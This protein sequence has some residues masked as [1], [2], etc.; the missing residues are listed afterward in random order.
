MT[1]FGNS[2]YT[3]HFLG[4]AHLPLSREYLSCAFTQKILKQ[5]KMFLSLGHRVYLYGARSTVPGYDRIEDYLDPKGIYN[6]LLTIV[7]THTVADIA[8]DYGDGD[9]KFEIG[10]DYTLG[11]YRHDFDA[12]TKPSTQKFYDTAI[13]HIKATAQPDHFLLLSMGAYHH[14][15]ADAVQLYLRCES[16][17]GYRGSHKNNWRCFESAGIQHFTYGAESNGACVNG[18]NYD[19]VIP[20]CFDPAEFT[21]SPIPPGQR[22][23]PDGEPYA[24][25]IGRM[26]SRKGILTAFAACE[27]LNLKLILVGQGGRVE[28]DTFVTDEFRTTPTCPWEYQGFADVA[29]RRNLFTNA[30]L[31]FVPTDYIEPFA[32]VHIESMISGTPV[33]T[34]DFGVFPTT[35]KNGINGYRCHSLDDFV[36]AARQCQQWKHAVPRAEGKRYLL[37]QVRWD[38]QQWFDDLY[39]V[40]LSTLYPDQQHGW[41]QD[42]PEG[43]PQVWR[44]HLAER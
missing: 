23:D 11:E 40:Y 31:T 41:Y 9:E 42:Y 37:D 6:D 19:R 29:K 3:L 12:P 13:A 35:V 17:I 4:L 30:L 43:D 16:G 25:F 14:P 32:G 7:E 5:T 26:I 21:Y 28:G 15:V 22:H 20:N 34:T 38:Y 39:N 33:L 44:A 8:K 1:T 36:W 18:A 27:R 2:K 24:L 10:Y